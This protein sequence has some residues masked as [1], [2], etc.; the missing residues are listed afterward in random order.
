VAKLET[1]VCDVC[2]ATKGV[3]NGWWQLLV[4]RRVESGHQQLIL[5]PFGEL[6]SRLDAVDLC[7]QPCVLRKVEEFMTGVQR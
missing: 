1:Y 2:G 3:E 7:G 4:Q 6:S 5:A